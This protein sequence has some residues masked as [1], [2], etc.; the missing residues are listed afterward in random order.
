[1]GRIFLTIWDGGG[2]D[3]Y[4]MSNYVDDAL[5]DLAPGGF[6]RLSQAQLANKSSGIKVNGNVYNAFQYNG[7][8]RSLIENA[9]GGSGNDKV[10]GNAA[11]NELKGN[12]GNDELTGRGGADRL[13][14]GAGSDD[15]IG[16][17]GADKLDGGAG[18]DFAGH[19]HAS[20]GVVANLS[21]SWRNTG[22]AAGDVYIDIEG[23]GGSR[24]NDTLTGNGSG[25]D[26]YGHD[27]HDRLLGQAGNDHLSGGA[28][29]DFLAGGAGADGLNGG[30]GFD[31][32]IYDW[33]SSGVTA[34]LSNAANNSGEAASDVYESIERLAGSGF[35]DRLTG[36][37]LANEL[38]GNGGDDTLQGGAAADT[39]S[40][41]D[42]H[43]LLVGGAGCDHLVG[44]TG[45]DIVRFEAALG[46][47]NIDTVAD[48]T[49][50]SD[51]LQLSRGVFTAFTYQGAV[52]AE[53][54]TIGASA[55][56]AAQ[57]LVYN[58]AT[59]AV[60]YDADEAGGAAQVQ[61]ATLGKYLTLKASDFALI[62]V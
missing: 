18:F 16:D 46:A 45:S 3:T 12:G 53:Q 33:A 26:L 23:L 52:A 30:A 54:F 59:G 57:R 14:G 2:I 49:V 43:D 34:D 20:A 29:D 55:T 36:N 4:D 11:Q 19:Y 8:S 13:Y 47:P 48:F 10:R 62:W 24:F 32:A 5:I 15:L 1:L 60:S 25:N 42:G 38:Y 22:E 37:G 27:G 40:G 51:K 50:G 28:G 17:E 58:S 39:L 41:G 21:E 35:G 7:D 44:G 6:S 31:M 56:T 9:Y 61:F